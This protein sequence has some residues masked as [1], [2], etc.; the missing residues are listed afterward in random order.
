[1][2][3]QPVHI[4]K[5][6]CFD[7]EFD[8]APETELTSLL[9]RCNENENRLQRLN[10]DLSKVLS[11]AICFSEPPDDKSSGLCSGGV[12]GGLQSAMSTTTVQIDRME[13]LLNRLNG[14]V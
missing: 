8:P 11:R 14:L 3:K 12:I 9:A 10:D 5:P 1:M 4:S 2:K 7:P 13:S 6:V